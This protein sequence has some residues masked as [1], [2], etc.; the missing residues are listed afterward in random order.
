MGKGKESKSKGNVSSGKHSTVSTATR[1]AMRE[2]YLRS[3]ERPVNQLKAV[4][5]G[6]DVVMTIPNPDKEQ[7]NRPFI[8]KRISAKEWNADRTAFT[9]R[10]DG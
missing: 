4:E 6:K 8:K 10:G 1:R 7:T 2:Q 5:S 9:I 3:G